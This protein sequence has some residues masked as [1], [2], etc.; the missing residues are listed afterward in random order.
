[1]P[2]G[3]FSITQSAFSF[4]SVDFADGSA[5]EGGAIYFTDSFKDPAKNRR[6]DIQN[7]TFKNNRGNSG[8]AIYLNWDIRTIE[9]SF[10]ENNSAT[11]VELEGSGGAIMYA[12]TSQ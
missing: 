7:C 10:F 1:M 6:L 3:F 5:Y 12:C 11:N 4:H 9:N 8:G 2:G